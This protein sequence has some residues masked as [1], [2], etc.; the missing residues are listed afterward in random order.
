MFFKLSVILFSNIVPYNH[1][2][3]MKLDENSKAL[4]GFEDVSTSAK[5][6]YGPTTKKAIRKPLTNAIYA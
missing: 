4:T 6:Q 3:L 2:H 1:T 5:A